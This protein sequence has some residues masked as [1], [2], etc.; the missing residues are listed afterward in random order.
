MHI[1]I[2]GGASTIGAT[3]AYTLASEEPTIDITLVDKAEDP[4]WAHAVDVTHSV[5]HSIRGPVAAP[6][7]ESFG[8][9]RTVG[10]DELGTLEP[11]P[12]LAVFT[13][14]AP[15]PENTTGTDARE[16][17]LDR[18]RSVVDAVAAELRK[19]NPLPVLMI[20]NP[21]DRLTYRLWQRLE[22]PR[23]YFL[24]Y[25]LSETARTAYKIGELRDVPWTSVGCPVI[26]EHGDEIIPVFS[27]LHIDGEPTT[28]SETERS[29][30]REYVREIPFKIASKR[31]PEE[32]SRWVTSA[33]VMRLIRRMFTED[34]DG[35]SDGKN[36]EQSVNAGVEPTVCL[37]TPVDGEY[38]LSGGC[39][40]VPVKL[41]SNGA[42]EILEWSLTPDER[43]RFERAHESICMD[44]K[45]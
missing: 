18:N 19:L 32:T 43:Q 3:V 8:S 33:G 34:T 44:L 22:W 6:T 39:L 27:R 5:F 26:G 30:V 16:A 1:A 7:A 2:I 24:G 38:G 45:L 28:L 13:A 25:S 40:S 36:G 15:K 4:S 9:I 37:S 12:D 29:T 10:A 35:R 23:R 14:A 20:T 42:E 41:T 11:E 31:G 17:E 21:I